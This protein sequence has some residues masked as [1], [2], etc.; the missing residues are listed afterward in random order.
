MLFRGG[1]R[2]VF[3]RHHEKYRV[4]PIPLFSASFYQ[5]RSGMPSGPPVLHNL[6]HHLLQR[7]VFVVSCHDFCIRR[8]L[9]T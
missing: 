8:I 6:D 2:R 9:E 3:L 7:L 1:Y 4:V 5:S